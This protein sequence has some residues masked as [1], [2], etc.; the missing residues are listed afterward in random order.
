MVTS[1]IIK[2]LHDISKILAQS[3]DQFDRV[4]ITDKGVFIS[5][6]MYAVNIRFRD[7]KYHLKLVRIAD[8]KQSNP[9]VKRMLDNLD[10]VEGFVKA[11]T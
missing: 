9:T 2:L 11:L 10:Q 4:S 8:S 7:G 3:V 6:P 1:T 5:N